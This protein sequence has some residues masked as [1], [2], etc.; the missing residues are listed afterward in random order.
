MNIPV[1]QRVLPHVD[2]HCERHPEK[3]HTQENMRSP[4]RSRITLESASS[5]RELAQ[6][7]LCYWQRGQRATSLRQHRGALGP[8]SA[9]SAFGVGGQVVQLVHRVENI[10]DLHAR[11][12]MLG[13]ELLQHGVRK[14]KTRKH[15]DNS[16]PKWLHTTQKRTQKQR[17]A[18]TT[19]NHAQRCTQ[20]S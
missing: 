19:I 7:E 10:T 13:H 4:C 6:D 14:R 11:N 9:S 12:R 16:N 2:D 3:A 1:L 18:H 20:R 8:P 5:L 17:H 15:A